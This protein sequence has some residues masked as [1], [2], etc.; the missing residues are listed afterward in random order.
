MKQYEV[1]RWLDEW[2]G[3]EYNDGQTN[4]LVVQ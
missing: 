2:V 1:F 3:K 4:G